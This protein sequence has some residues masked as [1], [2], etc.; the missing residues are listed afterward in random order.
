VFSRKAKRTSVAA[1]DTFAQLRIDLKLP[2]LIQRGGQLFPTLWRNARGSF[3]Q[4][5]TAGGRHFSRLSG[6]IL[7]EE[8][9]RMWKNVEECGRM[10][11]NVE[12][13]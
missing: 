10:W 3:W 12:E 4:L 1:E 2:L 6:K 8:C 5:A 9:G 7:V 13:L 11:K